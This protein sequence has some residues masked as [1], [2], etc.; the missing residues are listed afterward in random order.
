VVAVT[1]TVDMLT[2][3]KL[4]AAIKSAAQTSRRPSSST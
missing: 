1:G 4:E 2:A 3:P